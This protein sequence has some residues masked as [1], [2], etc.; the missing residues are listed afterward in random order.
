MEHYHLRKY[1]GPEV[2]KRVRA[3]YEEGQTGPEVA[4]RYDVGL[5]NLRKKAR[6]EGWSR[7]DQAAAA[8]RALS[9]PDPAPADEAPVRP[10]AAVA[11]AVARASSALADGRASEAAGLLR[12][13][14][15]LTRLTVDERDAAEPADEAPLT[16]EED[17]AR[18]AAAKKGWDDM[19][20]LIEAQADALAR[21]ILADVPYAPL[22]HSGFVAAWRAQYL[23]PEAAARDLARMQADSP[24][25]VP[26]HWRD[27]GQPRPVDEV[28][29]L[30][31]PVYRR[32]IRR[33]AGLP[34]LGP[35]DEG[36]WG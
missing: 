19:L 17:A 11:A 7:A 20:D 10:A 4:R 32:Q 22:V 13:A 30:Y 29:A 15:G 9:D 34:P 2:W 5:A 33:Q 31:Y 14:E 35:G 6:N 12:A 18:E 8:D 24:Q 16:P 36:G 27:D 1:R 23:G 28:R 25:R 21:H 3:A 26:F